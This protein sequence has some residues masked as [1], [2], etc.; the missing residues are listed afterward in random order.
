[1]RVEVNPWPDE[2]YCTTSHMAG[3]PSANMSGSLRGWCLA[4]PVSSHP[5]P[6]ARE[7]HDR[8]QS[9][10]LIASPACRSMGA[11]SRL[12]PRSGKGWLGPA[13]R[14][15]CPF[16]LPIL[17]RLLARVLLLGS[18]LGG[19]V[20][21]VGISEGAAGRARH[22]GLLPIKLDIGIVALAE[23][24]VAIAGHQMADLPQPHLTVGLGVPASCNVEI[25]RCVRS[26]QH[27]DL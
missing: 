11:V 15:T 13:N 6:D 4:R 23:R 26:F 21:L 14:R 8:H 10:S 22:D 20:P 5:D 3:F 7:L 27:L 18:R 19:V 24:A 9:L 25:E 1:L 17:A 2:S 12:V 16:R